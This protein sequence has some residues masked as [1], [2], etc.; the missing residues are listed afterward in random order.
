MVAQSAYRAAA[1]TERETKR[2]RLD[3][4]LAARALDAVVLR[5]PANLAWYLGGARVHVVPGEPIA[6]L[7]VARDGEELRTSVIESPRLVAEEL[8]P[9]APPLRALPWWEPLDPPAAAGRRGS[10]RPRGDEEDV[11]GDLLDARAALLEP[12]LERYRAL[13]RD[14]AAATG[15]ALRDA[16]PRDSEMGLAGRAARRLYERGVEP[17]VLL[18]AGEERLP[19]H[20][21]PLPTAAPLGARAML[22][23]CGRRHGLICAVTRMRA[24]SP[25]GAAERDRYAALLRIEAAYLDAT[26]PGARI[27]DIVAAGAAAYAAH[28]FPADEWHA[29]HQGG[30]I[31]YATRDYLASPAT[32]HAAADRQ[33]FAWNPSGGGFKVE[34]TVLATAAGPEILSPDL[35]W[36]SVAVAGRQRPDVLA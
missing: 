17:V 22:V 14:T 32:G 3:A 24:F 36:P 1:M 11:A 26:R 8:A 35:G 20:R 27:G 19:L 21:H 25:L 10:D 7:T 5:D 4:I 34:D 31:G 29:H 9:D 12:E 18:A 13:C 6:E 15:A 2:E 28:G 23:V 33:A 16:Q 30:P